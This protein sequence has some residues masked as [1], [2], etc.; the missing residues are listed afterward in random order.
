M[1]FCAAGNSLKP[2]LFGESFTGCA[3]SNLGPIAIV[4]KLKSVYD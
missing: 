3:G 4:S 2:V 1:G